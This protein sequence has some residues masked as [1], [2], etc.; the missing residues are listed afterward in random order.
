MHEGFFECL[1]T[2]LDNSRVT[3]LE[4][5]AALAGRFL[6]ML[7]YSAYVCLHTRVNRKERALAFPS[8]VGRRGGRA[9]RGG[10]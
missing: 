7:R 6:K 2:L 4:L 8:L 10:R 9:L 3:Y 5:G 1:V